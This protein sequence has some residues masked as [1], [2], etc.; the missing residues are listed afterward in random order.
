MSSTSTR[1]SQRVPLPLPTAATFIALQLLDLSTRFPAEYFT[2]VAI[3]AHGL[4]DAQLE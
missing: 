3:M 1:K 4:S 2:S